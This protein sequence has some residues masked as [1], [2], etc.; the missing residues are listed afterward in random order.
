[1]TRER[2]RVV[3]GV[4]YDIRDIPFRWSEG[5]LGSPQDGIDQTRCRAAVVHGR[6]GS[7][8]CA[9]RPR[10]GSEWCA[11]HHPEASQRRRERMKAKYQ[12]ERAADRARQADRLSWNAI[13]RFLCPTCI[14][15]ITTYLDERENTPDA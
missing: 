9:V 6:G 5:S 14:A 1:V 10:L 15:A 8:Q 13:Y 7:Y 2:D 11:I 12:R 3:E 4:E